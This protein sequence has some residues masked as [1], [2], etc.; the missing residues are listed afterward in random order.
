MKLK[1]IAN[2]SIQTTMPADVL[3][4]K[5]TWIL[6]IVDQIQSFF[7]SG[8][9][10]PNIAKIIL[11]EADKYN[12]IVAQDCIASEDY[13]FMLVCDNPKQILLSIIENIYE[14]GEQ[15]LKDS[16]NPITVMM[17]LYEREY[18]LDLNGTRLCYSVYSS[19]P[20]NY[21]LKSFACRAIANVRT[22]YNYIDPE[23]CVMIGDKI[24]ELHPLYD[25]RTKE[26]RIIG[27]KKKIH[28]QFDKKK[29]NDRLDIIAKL[30]E[31]VRSNLEIAK[32]VIFVNTLSECSSSA[33]DLIYTNFKIKKALD[34]YLSKLISSSYESYTF[35]AFLHS[36]FKIPNDF[37]MRK[38][39][40]LINN[41]STKVP[42]YIA[43]LYDLATY[44]PVPCTKF[45]IRDTFIYMA[46]PIIKL[47]MLYIDMYLVEHKSKTVNPTRSEE[48]YKSKMMAAF[49]SLTT[50]D[51]SPEWVGM[52]LDEIYEKNK[53]NNSMKV[54]SLSDTM[55]V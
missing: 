12:A 41:K 49:N 32:G 43:N 33:M 31:Y 29:N 16:V 46:H 47:R 40:Y 53:F 5:L 30:M 23:S 18:M 37:I 54:T 22:F 11:S 50:H 17:K 2:Y 55:F 36:D 34:E 25:Y 21:L 19:V 10:S 13:T 4:R 7:I 6:N 26:H 15:S 24:K 9:K 44:M 3:D 8:L 39:S 20:S 45:T 42:T 14:H 1:N 48:L 28:R 51:K 27:G 52:Y 38:H 35:K